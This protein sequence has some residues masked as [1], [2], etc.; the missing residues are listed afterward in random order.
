MNLKFVFPLFLFFAAAV[1]PGQS[2]LRDEGI[3]LYKQGNDAGA[4]KALEKVVK[5]K[6]FENDGEAWNTLGL[7]YLRNESPKK[8][9]KA[10]EMAVRAKPEIDIYHANLSYVYLMNRQLPKSEESAEKALQINPNN[11]FARYV[12]AVRHYWEGDLEG[13]LANVDSIFSK[14]PS[15]APAYLLKSDLLMSRF[16]KRV[17]VHHNVLNEIDLLGQAVDVLE[18]GYKNAKVEADKKLLS[19]QLNSMR[20]FLEHYRKRKV[21]GDLETPS[22]PATDTTPVK[23]TYQPKATYTDTARQANVS[24]AVRLAILLGAD[25]KVSHILKL[26]GIGYGLDEQAIR[27]ARAI[28]F[29]PKKVD[30][31]PVAVIVIREY[32]F[33]VF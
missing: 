4:I 6:N 29:E 9:R 32:T 7:A 2:A 21:V 1:T 19:E 20:Y 18:S 15:F 25:G 13:A 33:T 8:A 30:G 11:S 14:N 16:G 23:I 17:A 28:K 5:Q 3:S 31:K 27:A 22:A 10:L 24:G 12:I 26:W